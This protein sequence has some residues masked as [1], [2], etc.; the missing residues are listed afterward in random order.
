LCDLE[1]LREAGVSAAIV[2]MALYTG[3]LNPADIDQDM[4]G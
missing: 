3:Q 2:G 1:A 4:K